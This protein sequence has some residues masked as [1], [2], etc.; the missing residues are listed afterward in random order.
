MEEVMMKDGQDGV[1]DR[2]LGACLEIACEPTGR[3]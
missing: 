3:Y 2:S 1:G